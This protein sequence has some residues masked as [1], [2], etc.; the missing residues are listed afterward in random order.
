MLSQRW[1]PF[2]V[3]SASDKNFS[4][5]A[6]CAMKLI[7]R[8]IRINLHVK[9]VHILLRLSMRENLFLVCSVCDKIV[10]TYAQHAHAIILENYF[11]IPN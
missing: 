2:H 7:P 11:K 10:S 9:P 6:Q 1:N 8:M 5:Y 4:A 3:C